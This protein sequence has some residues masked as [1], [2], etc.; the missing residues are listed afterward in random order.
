MFLALTVATLF[1]AITPVK[2]WWYPI[3]PFV[4]IGGS[5]VLALMLLIHSLGPSLLGAAVVLAGL[6]ARWLLTRNQ[7]TAFASVADSP[8]ALPPESA[9]LNSES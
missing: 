6:P 5:G 7:T 1:R 8:N 3:S 2:R 4:F 9:S